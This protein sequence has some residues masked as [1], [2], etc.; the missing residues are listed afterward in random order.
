M[1]N[2]DYE[3]F[4][5]ATIT[6][7][8]PL[9]RQLLGHYCQ[10]L[11]DKALPRK[12]WPPRAEL[13][14]IT[15]AHDKSISRALRALVGKG[16]LFRITLASKERGKRAEYGVNLE[17]LKSYQVTAKLPITNSDT[18]L[19]VT[20]EYHESNLEVLVSNS[21]VLLRELT[22]YPKPIKPIKPIKRINVERWQVI[23]SYLPESVKRLIKPNQNSENLLDELV[24]QGTSITAIRDTVAKVDY[25]NAYKVGGLFIATLEKLAGV[26]SA[27]ENSP[28]PHCGSCDKETRQFDEPSLV[29][30][31]LTFNCPNCHPLKKQL[32][33]R[34]PSEIEAN[35]SNLF[36]DVN[37]S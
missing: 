17:L 28:Y 30:G 6:G 32:E 9:E 21:G 2:H 26:K 11:S 5:K 34:S 15:G 18:P 7:L 13:I 1:S 33:T 3:L 22:S 29:N 27:R 19:E 16:F 20:P 10:R 12:A 8:P 4:T 14:R 36:R 25:A 24:R 35:F 23:T 31:E 37:E